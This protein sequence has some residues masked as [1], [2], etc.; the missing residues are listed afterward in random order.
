M[1]YIHFYFQQLMNA[2]AIH[3]RM[4]VLVVTI[5]IFITVTVLLASLEL[6][7]KQVS[8][9]IFHI[10]YCRSILIN[11]LSSCRI[12][13]AISWYM[14]VSQSSSLSTYTMSYI[15]HKQLFQHSFITEINNIYEI[16]TW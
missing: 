15:V 10:Y 3:V 9:V 7:V 6:I 2:P 8:Y 12:S 16:A 11:K 4:V 14:Y 13:M 5:T 1:E